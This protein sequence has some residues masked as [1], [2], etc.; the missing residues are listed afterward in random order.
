MSS[1]STSASAA[2]P[3][4]AARAGGTVRLIATYLVL[5]TLALSPLLWASVPPLV[6]YPDH[7]ARMWIL[8]QNGALPKLAS[9]YS[10]DWR[11]L[12]DL[13]MDLVV[14]PLAQILP[15]ETAGRIFIALTLLSLLAGTVAL[16]R[17]LY[18]RT[19]LWPL[20]ALLFLYNAAFF[21][22]FLNCLFGIGISLLAFSGW[23]AS[24][25]WRSAPRIVL[26]G[27]VASM[28]FFLHLFAFCLYGLAIGSYECGQR[29]AARE[30]SLRGLFGLCMA[31]LQ[32]IPGL[33]LW[34]ASLAKAGPRYMEYGNLGAKVYALQS[35]FTFGPQAVALDK[36][37]LVFCLGLTATAIA[38]RAFKLAPE[39]RLTL[40]AMILAA[41]AMPNWMSGSWLA[42]IRIPVAIPFVL[43][44]S[45]TL[46]TSRI[47]GAGWFA[48][49][50]VALLILR[51]WAV[52]EG[53][54]DTDAR[55]AEFRT[56]ARV[57]KPGA[58]LLVVDDTPK[59]EREADGAP[60]FLAERWD[61]TYSHMAALAV[62]DRSAFIPYLFTG[63]TSVA[64]A[65]RNAGLFQSQAAPLSSAMLLEAAS[66]APGDPRY[67]ERDFLGEVP[68]WGGWPRHFDFVLW[69][70]FTSPP[71]IYLGLLEPV[72]EGSFFR[73][74]R[75]QRP[76]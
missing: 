39:M 75:V 35:P 74:Y 24:R 65:E 70:D 44:A 38:S 19:G 2:L 16:H 21:W 59:G 57:I 4:S 45:S 26:F 23:I 32:F 36:I 54:H 61:E 47:R 43:I 73:I 67:A 20:A 30:R 7:L 22:G 41:V 10:V 66:A 25:E 8:A 55:F 11:V 1:L 69:I 60:S 6:D 14:P 33:A 71:P 64:A 15:L 12:P 76:S 27:A 62:I 51:V 34:I 13:A 31:S 40:V 56:A 50:A 63:W 3:T 37:F 29:L 58:R 17:V 28:L 42:D 68:Y 72:T 5:V 18:G 46:D 9:N 52:S 53:W 48:I 49:A